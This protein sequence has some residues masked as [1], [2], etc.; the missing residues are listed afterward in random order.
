MSTIEIFKTNVKGK[1]AAANLTTDLQQLFPGYKITVDID[2][3]DKVMRVE[4]N[5]GEVKAQ[6]IIKLMKQKNVLCEVLSY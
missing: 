3:R 2:D 1:R 4:S 6:D 5:R